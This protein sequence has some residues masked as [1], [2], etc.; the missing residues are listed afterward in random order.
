M[1]SFL[2]PTFML[3]FLT[4]PNLLVRKIIAL[5]CL[6]S[7][8]PFIRFLRTSINIS[9][10][11]KLSPHTVFI[12]FIFFYLHNAPF[13]CSHCISSSL[14]ITPSLYACFSRLMFPLFFISPL[15]SHFYAY[16]PCL[17]RLRCLSVCLS[18][19]EDQEI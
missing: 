13:I 4:P 2:K 19:S 5:S 12:I 7:L 15:V 17:S 3:F 9:L 8:A 18:Y 6:P 14:S 1:F 11:Y 10:Y 16:N